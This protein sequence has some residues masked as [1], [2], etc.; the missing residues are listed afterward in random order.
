MPDGGGHAPVVPSLHGVPGRMA[1]TAAG[2]DYLIRVPGVAQAPVSDATLAAIL[3]WMLSEFS[4][5]TLP[6]D[7]APFTADEV[8]ESRGMLLPDPLSLRAKLFPDY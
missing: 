8:G 1:A 2:R 6:D 5:D 4:R 7:F 3:N